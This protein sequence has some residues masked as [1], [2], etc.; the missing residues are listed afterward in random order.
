MPMSSDW[1]VNPDVPGGIQ[2]L[3][4]APHFVI[5]PSFTKKGNALAV[6]DSFIWDAVM[7]RQRKQHE[8]QLNKEEPN[9]E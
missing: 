6:R 3:Y 9:N 8:E 7:D 2:P 5:D 4:N 1:L